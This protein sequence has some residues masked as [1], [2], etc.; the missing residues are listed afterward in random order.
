[1]GVVSFDTDPKGDGHAFL[2]DE[3]HGACDQHLTL[4]AGEMSYSGV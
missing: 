4:V 1:M 2:H 3:A